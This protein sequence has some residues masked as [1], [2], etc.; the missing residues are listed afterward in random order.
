MNSSVGV[1]SGHLSGV[2][3]GELLGQTIKSVVNAQ[4]E[5]DN[6][7]EAR[8]HEYE[9]AEEG[10][11]ALPPIWYI[12]NHVSIELEMS[13]SISQVADQPH[14]VCQTLNPA[15]VSLYGYTASSGMR[16]RVDMAPQG[17]LPLKPTLSE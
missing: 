2:E 14:V 5:M 8:R 1:N 13:A 16:V 17:V 9:Q 10:S 4:E 11:F 7:T 15:M 3:M 12:F 6:Y